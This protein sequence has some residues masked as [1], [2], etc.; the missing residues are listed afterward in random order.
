[1]IF[2]LAVIESERQRLN[3]QDSLKCPCFSMHRR[4]AVVI[5]LEILDACPRIDG[6][7]IALISSSSLGAVAK[8]YQIHI[9]TTVNDETSRCLNAIL[10]KHKLE[11]FERGGRLMIFRRH[12]L[13]AKST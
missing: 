13:E 6:D 4:E 12:K 1:M 9:T 3:Q 10:E 8:G 2:A 11:Y 5:L 7:T